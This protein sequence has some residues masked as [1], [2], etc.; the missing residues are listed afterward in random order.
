[1]DKIIR[2]WQKEIGV[3]THFD[4]SITNADGNISF[5]LA[6]DNGQQFYS[7]TKGIPSKTM[8]SFVEID[9]ILL[10]WYNNKKIKRYRD[11]TQ[12]QVSHP[13]KIKF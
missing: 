1:M 7:K 4:S 9:A 8:I 13:D 10:H 6:Y 12:I 2:S 3:S 5:I 11:Q